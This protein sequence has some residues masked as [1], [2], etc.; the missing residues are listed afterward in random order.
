MME[1][2]QVAAAACRRFVRQTIGHSHTRNPLSAS[3]FRKPIAGLALILAAL[4][5][6]LIW[7]LLFPRWHS[8]PPV[9][10]IAVLPLVNSSRDP[11]QEYFAESATDGLTAELAKISALRVISR[12]SAR[13]FKGTAKPETQIARELQVDGLVEGSVRREE[14]EV[15]VAIRLVD[16]R[17]GRQLW[18]SSYLRDLAGVQ[19]LQGDMARDLAHQAGVQLT[20]AEKARFNQ[21]HRV[22]PE[23]VELYLEGMEKLKKQDPRLAIDLLRLAIRKDANYAAAHAALADCY[24]RMGD[25][26]EQA[27]AEAFALQKAEALRAIE[28]DDSHPEPHLSLAM[29]AMNESW[30]WATAKQELD[31]ALALG[32]NSAD[33]HTAL[34]TYY[35]R[36]G[37]TKRG[38]EEAQ[39][40]L[41]L[42][43]V[44]LRPTAGLAYQYYFDRQYDKALEQIQRAIATHMNSDL[45]LSPLAVI[46]VELGD[47]STAILELKQHGD[48][49]HSLGHLGNAYARAGHSTEALAII[50]RLKQHIEVSGIGW[51]EVAL[52]YAGL[53]QNEKAF[54]WLEKA[55]RAHDKGVTYILIDPCIDPLRGDPRLLDLERRIGFPRE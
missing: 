33:V 37:L 13:T 2:P 36:I 7:K 8:L 11:V 51:Y 41:K 1:S 44:F 4:A 17:T 48:A 29:A 24:G 5:G 43:P 21:I 6:F 15:Y 55:Y 46:H 22:D 19:Q 50:E 18:S 54:E 38:I 12:N 10:S 26:G 3:L 52:I 9:R 30:D 42:D 53:H 31:R 34:A 14:R 49:P 39:I 35:Q 25:R 16:G 32:P 20:S 23:A 40:A 47:Y 45:F 27:Y 28:L